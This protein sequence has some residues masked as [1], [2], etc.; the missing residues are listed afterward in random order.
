MR[1][2][3]VDAASPKLATDWRNGV[4][5]TSRRWTLPLT[6]ATEIG[7]LHG[8]ALYRDQV[9]TNR[10]IAL[11]LQGRLAADKLQAGVRF[12]T[13]RGWQATVGLSDLGG[14]FYWWT[15]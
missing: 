10:E 4:S 1:F 7:V 3:D 11:Y 9:R 12:L 6:S 13:E 5:I 14:L 2:R 15:R 8:R